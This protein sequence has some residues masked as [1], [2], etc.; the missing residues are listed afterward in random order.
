MTQCWDIPLD[1]AMAARKVC[2]IQE[3]KQDTLAEIPLD[4]TVD[5]L[6][7]AGILDLCSL[8]HIVYATGL[9]GCQ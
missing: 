8:G 1:I 4:H 3:H 6:S 9:L 2:L 7:T 5:K